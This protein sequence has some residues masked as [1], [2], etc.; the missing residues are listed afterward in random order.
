MMVTLPG[1]FHELLGQSLGRG[2]GWQGGTLAPLHF[3]P[4]YSYRHSLLYHH[5]L[6]HKETSS[7]QMFTDK[8]YDLSELHQLD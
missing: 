4:E 6:L 7:R 8:P 2:I 5:F 3:S 1:D